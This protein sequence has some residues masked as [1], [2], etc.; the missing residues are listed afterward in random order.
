MGSRISDPSGTRTAMIPRIEEN[1]P[2]ALRR[3]GNRMSFIPKAGAP[4]PWA[5]ANAGSS[6]IAAARMIPA[7]RVTS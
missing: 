2:T 6:A 4:S 3:S 1:T 5:A 7:T